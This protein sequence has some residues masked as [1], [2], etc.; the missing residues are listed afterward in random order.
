M[1]VKETRVDGT[2]EETWEDMGEK[3]DN[4]EHIVFINEDYFTLEHLLGID[5]GD[6][7]DNHSVNSLLRRHTYPQIFIGKSRMG[8]GKTTLLGRLADTDLGIVMGRLGLVANE[9]PSILSISPRRDL[10]QFTG[11]MLKLVSYTDDEKMAEHWRRLYGDERS[12]ENDDELLCAQS[13]LSICVNSLKRLKDRHEGYDVLV[14]DE[15]ATTALAM[16]SKHMLPRVRE[17][18]QVLR[19][20][21]KNSKY[22]ILLAA[23]GTPRMAKTLLPFVD[24]DDPS[25]LRITIN[26]GG[27]GGISGHD[28]YMSYDFVETCRVLKRYVQEGKSVYVPTNYKVFAKKLVEFCVGYLGLTED[29]VMIYQK[30]SP[31]KLKKEIIYDPEWRLGH[32]V[33]PSHPKSRL[34]PY[35]KVRVFIA[36]PA[37]GV[38]FSV[39]GDLFDVTI[40][41]FFTYPLTVP[42]NVQ[43]IARIRGVKEKTIICYYQS[44]QAKRTK[45]SKMMSNDQTRLENAIKTYEDMIA[46]IDP[47]RF[48]RLPDGGVR[49]FAVH[50]EVQARLS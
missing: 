3:Y 31:R 2:R 42:G 21:V 18:M 49:S 41:F 19:F 28:L 45:Y 26:N 38:G 10:A 25:N 44:R 22:V 17:T 23:D 20:L 14:M 1:S 7:D 43:H 37:F 50:C 36:T 35:T 4:E 13:R 48:D 32:V 29:E 8:T 27:I 9:Q 40:G 12:P 15:F 33:S 30:D 16:I 24:W 46:N 6:N 34:D 5:E 47:D 11:E 39:K